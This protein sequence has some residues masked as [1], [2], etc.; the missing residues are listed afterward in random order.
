MLF[1][2][3]KG[4]FSMQDIRFAGKVGYYIDNIDFIHLTRNKDS[5]CRMKDGKDKYSLIFT[6][7]GKMSYFPERECGGGLIAEHG[8]L[9][10][11]PGKFRTQADIR[12]TGLP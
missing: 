10:F 2:N 11:M 4:D 1:D 12:L 7:A 5:Y 3:P 9:C 6:A 8:A